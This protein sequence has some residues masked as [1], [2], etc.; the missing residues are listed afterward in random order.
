VASKFKASTTGI[1]VQRF[2]A[3]QAETADWADRSWGRALSS[4]NRKA[5]VF[6][7]RR[8]EFNA[9]G[10]IRLIS[11]ISRIRVEPLNLDAS[12]DVALAGS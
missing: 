1:Q 3:D 8:G 11:C 5:I 12:R 10:A 6:L 2:D 4:R 7:W 9:P